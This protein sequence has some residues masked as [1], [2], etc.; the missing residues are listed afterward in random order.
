[1]DISWPTP[2]PFNMTRE[3]NMLGVQAAVVNVGMEGLAMLLVSRTRLREW[4]MPTLPLLEMIRCVRLEKHDRAP[5]LLPCLGDAVP[6]FLT[7]RSVR[8][9]SLLL[10]NVGVPVRTDV[11][12]GSPTLAELVKLMRLRLSSLRTPLIPLIAAA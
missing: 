12:L 10:P 3:V 4:L 6:F 1:M 5:F 11:P 8:L 9:L 2:A 7:V